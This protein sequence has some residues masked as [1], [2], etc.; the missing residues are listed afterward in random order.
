MELDM[1]TK[2]KTEYPTQVDLD[3]DAQALVCKLTNARLGIVNTKLLEL[4]RE[5]AQLKQDMEH[6]TNNVVPGCCDQIVYEIEE[7]ISRVG[8][9]INKYAEEIT[10]LNSILEAL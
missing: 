8:Y 6:I 7:A 5:D 9:V 4:I 10:L 2:H 1:Q 3:F